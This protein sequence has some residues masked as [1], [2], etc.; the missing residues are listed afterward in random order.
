MLTDPLPPK[1][2]LLQACRGDQ[3]VDHPLLRLA[4][5]LSDL[6]EQRLYAARETIADRRHIDQID[7]RR[8]RLVR[9][10]DRWVTLQLP[11]SHGAAY[12]HTETVGAVIDRL[13]QFT[14]CAF[15]ALAS[16][17]QWELGDAWEQLAELA[18]GY[19]DLAAEVCAGRRR[20]PGGP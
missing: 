15:A 20:L 12:I 2:Q 7:V 1:H 5:E 3:S 4:R 16:A 14:A 10:I 8:A 11:P 6:H 13:A 18:V 17:S 19:D 9:D